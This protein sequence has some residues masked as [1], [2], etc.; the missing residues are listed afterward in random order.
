MAAPVVTGVVALI[1]ERSPALTPAQVKS[2]LKAT[3]TALPYGSAVTTGS[4]MVNAPAAVAALT[5][6]ADPAA[7]PVSA[8][9]EMYSWIFGQPLTWRDLTYHGGVDSSGTPWSQVTWTNA[10]WDRTTWQ[11]VD[12]TAFNWSAVTWQDISWEDISWEGI[13]WE[14]IS[15]EVVPVKDKGRKGRGW[16]VLD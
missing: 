1:L 6:T 2:R 15:W 11:N 5:D 14:D 4:G 9:S 13:T 8:A 7:T 3:A 10:V 16:K 12:W